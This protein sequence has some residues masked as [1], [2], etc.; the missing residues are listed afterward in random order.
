MLEK[1]VRKKYFRARKARLSI[2]LLILFSLFLVY[3]AKNI[4]GRTEPGVSFLLV[5]FVFAVL[6]FL[7]FVIVI[8]IFLSARLKDPFKR[9]DMEMDD[10]ISGNSSRQLNLRKNDSPHLKSFVSKV[11]KVLDESEKTLLSKEKLS[12]HAAPDI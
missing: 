12:K 1:N 3:T 8:F 4:L 5:P 9:L 2:A 7:C 10:R 6:L 11:N